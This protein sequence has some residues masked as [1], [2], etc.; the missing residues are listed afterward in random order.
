LEEK[1]KSLQKPSSSMGPTDTRVH[2]LQVK[3]KKNIF[4]LLLGKNAPAKAS[5]GRKDLFQLTVHASP[6]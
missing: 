6:S 5:W 4:F 2:E 1:S 3:K